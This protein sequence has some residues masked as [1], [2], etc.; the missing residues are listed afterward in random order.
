MRPGNLR[1]PFVRYFPLGTVLYHEIGHHIHAEHIP[2][3]D[4]KENVAEDWSDKLLQR[5]YRI[6]YWYL[7]P[8]LRPLAFFIK[9]GRSV[10]TRYRR[11]NGGQ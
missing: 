8:L 6:H 7:M 5:F 1:V 4:G 11:S 3:H 10:K 9:L 2:I